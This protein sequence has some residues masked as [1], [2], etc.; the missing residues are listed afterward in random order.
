MKGNRLTRQKEM[1]ERREGGREGGEKG[2]R[3]G[4]NIDRKDPR[5]IFPY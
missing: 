3:D 4:N 5:A 2:D 1:K